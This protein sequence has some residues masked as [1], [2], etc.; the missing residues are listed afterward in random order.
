MPFI[1]K[2]LRLFGSIESKF[3]SS[4][5]AKGEL[6]ISKEYAKKNTFTK[7]RM[8]VSHQSKNM[9]FEVNEKAKWRIKLSLKPIK[10]VKAYIE[11]NDRFASLIEISVLI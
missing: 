7:F 4:I 2:K 8:K 5:G 11:I 3:H 6:E 1:P 9:S 10:Y